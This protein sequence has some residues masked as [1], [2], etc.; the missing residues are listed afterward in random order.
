LSGAM[1]GGGVLLKI[2]SIKRVA[3]VVALSFI[4]S[5]TV[6]ASLD[7]RVSIY[8]LTIGFHQ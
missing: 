5:Q 6:E 3:F 2:T 1:C 7:S 8:V 4:N